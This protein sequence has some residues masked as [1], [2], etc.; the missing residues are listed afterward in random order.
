MIKLSK[1]SGQLVL[2]Y[3]PDRFNSGGWIDAKLKQDG[4]VTLRRTFT[5]AA[6][7]LVPPLQDPVE[8]EDAE[9]RERTFKLGVV[10]GSYYRVDKSNSSE[11]GEK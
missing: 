7:D 10:D 9:D 5:F 1:Q 4:E 11:K 2:V 3:Q 6:T 8:D